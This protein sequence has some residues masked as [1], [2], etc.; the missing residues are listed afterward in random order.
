M[1]VFRFTFLVGMMWSFQPTGAADVHIY[2]SP[3]GNDANNGTSPDHPVHS[4]QHALDTLKSVH[5]DNAYVELMA[6]HYDIN[7][8]LHVYVNN[9]HLRS[10]QHQPVY[11]T[12]GRRVPSG[13]FKHVTDH[14]AISKLPAQA[15][16][17][18][19]VVHLP[20][21]GVTDYGTFGNYGGHSHRVAP[22]EVF[23]NSKPLRLAQW[24]NEGYLN[25]VEVPDGSNGSRFRYNSSVPRT[26]S[27]QDDVLVHG[28]W[29]WSW[30]DGVQ[31][32]A[33]LNT[34]TGTVTLAR[35]PTY[36]LRIGHFGEA[37]ASYQKQGGYFRFINVLEE[38]DSPGEYYM[39]AKSGNLYVWMPNADGNLHTSDSIYV[40][41]VN[42][43]IEVRA[44]GNDI[45]FSDFTL[46]VCREYGI[47]G[48]K[49][50]NFQ[51]LNMEIR[52]TGSYAALCSDCRNV[53]VSQCLI[54]DVDGGL[55][56]SGGDRKLL[57]SSGA[58]LEHNEIYN[59]SRV[60]A[61]G[62][63]AIYANGVG[64]IVRH[65]SIYNGQY[66]GVN[67]F[68]NDIVMEFNHVH[69]TCMNASDCGAFHT[70]RDWTTRGNVIRNNLVH[71]NLRLVPGADVRGVML[72]DQS[73]STHITNNVFFNNDVHVNIGGGRDNVVSGNVMYGAERF[74][75]QV[76]GRGLGR[77]DYKDFIN[78]RLHNM[79]YTGA[80][81]SM[82][83]PKLA[84]I[85]AHN[86]SL[87]EGNEISKNVVYNSGH[88]GFIPTLHGWI[89]NKR[90]FNVTDTGFAIN[91][92]DF[93]DAAHGDF[94][95]RCY[96]ADWANRVNFLQP[97]SP[98]QYGAQKTVGPIHLHRMPAHLTSQPHS[99]PCTTQAPVTSSPAVA[100]LPD[101]SGSNHLYNVTSQGCWLIV[102]K[103]SA[104][105]AAVGMYRDTVGERQ[106][107][108]DQNETACM[109]RAVHTWKSCGGH[110]D[111]QVAAIYGP[112]G[113]TTLAG[114]G[115]YMAMYG[116]PQHGGPADGHAVATGKIYRDGYAEQHQGAATDEG[117]CLSRS[118]AQ[119]RY[120]GSYANHPITSIF[121]PTGAV[122]TAG[123]GCW[124]HVQSC[125]H[126]TGNHT[127]F[128]DAWGA[129]NLHTDENESAC[130][131]Q[132][133][134]YWQQ[135]GSHPAHP[136]TAFYRP[137]THSRTYP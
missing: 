115:C 73:S 3:A 79:P 122:R 89:D 87:P 7:A 136:V 19:R 40:S 75:M 98:D 111:E 6:G 69:H 129:A 86:A 71:D 33:K 84:A 121:R 57:E 61:V 13:L 21:A 28:Y 109:E 110:K 68:G 49:L 15:R 42:N 78:H 70:G 53:Q 106:V 137:S 102:S 32:V 123:A 51:L 38:L 2:V 128:Y 8:T 4:I 116:C 58:V 80:L 52:N 90:F 88:V 1:V 45:S 100:Y 118:I 64:H 54:H 31:E 20:D 34:T 50:N 131:H 135:C 107:R 105:P 94:R 24:P 27:T 39:D 127:M 23:F 95:V 134:Y 60:V 30:H 85:D 22:L 83:Y 43:C 91:E 103:C 17:H 26:W 66:R 101:G 41:V 48:P 82:R 18:V 11:V 124:I 125:N 113:A 132:A 37:D 93:Y 12:G 63:D 47:K 92:G 108:A 14:S 96:M 67:Y 16:Q 55:F 74:S 133:R 76:D 36:G 77:D 104:H 9:V 97:L 120:C 99:G 56:I 46:E 25:I 72:D 114:D 117:A 130:L 10:Y 112:S 65:N 59:F 44:N 62:S 126:V 35:P 29:Y 119:W 5:Y 81:W